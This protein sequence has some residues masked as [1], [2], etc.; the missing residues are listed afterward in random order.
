VDKG[1]EGQTVDE[2][3]GFADFEGLGVVGEVAGG[4]QDATGRAFGGQDAK[5]FA[6]F[7]DSDLQDTP[8]FALNQNGFAVATEHEVDAAVCAPTPG[9][10]YVVSLA[11]VRLADELFEFTPGEVAE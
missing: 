5:E 3:K 4:D 8:L 9:F 7:V 6:D 10:L 1:G 2:V 11:P